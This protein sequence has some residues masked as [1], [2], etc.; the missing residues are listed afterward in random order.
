MKEKEVKVSISILNANFLILE[1]EIL[2]AKEVG[3]DWLHFDVMDGHFVPNISFGAP[4]LSCI[5]HKFKMFND[6][7]LMISDPLKYYEDFVKAGADLITFHYEAIDSEEKIYELIEKIH[8]KNVKVGI[9]IKPNTDVKVLLPFLDK[10]DLVLVMSVEP[11]FGGQKFILA[12][13]EKIR[14]LSEYKIKNGLKYLIEVDGGINDTT[15]KLCKKEG[16]DI[17]VIGSYLYKSNNVL[18]SYKKLEE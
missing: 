10:I 11:G 12:S 6:V 5:E 17:C 14:F 8:L 16:V 9:S 4:I 7:H 2:R 1:N 13:L 3:I 15:F 18:E